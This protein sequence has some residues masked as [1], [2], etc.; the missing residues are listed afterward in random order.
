MTLPTTDHGSE[1]PPPADYP[2][3]RPVARWRA[4][5]ARLLVQAARRLNGGAS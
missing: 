1:C 5:L 4:W 3:P 2:T